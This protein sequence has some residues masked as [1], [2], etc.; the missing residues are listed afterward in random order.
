MRAYALL[1]P[2]SFSTFPRIPEA[3]LHACRP[4]RPPRFAQIRFHVAGPN[5]AGLVL[6]QARAHT[7]APSSRFTAT[8]RLRT[9]LA[10]GCTTPRP[11]SP[12]CDSCL[13]FLSLSPSPHSTQGRV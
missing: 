7:L 11:P 13:R 10:W 3:T 2:S 1:N 8:T 6:V 5:G 12:A 4:P 9:P